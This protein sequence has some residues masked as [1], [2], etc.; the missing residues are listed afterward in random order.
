LTLT[1]RLRALRDVLQDGLVER[2]TAVRLALLAALAGEHLLLIGPP[3]T[4]KSLV[5]RR[6]GLA[7][8]DAK[9]FERLLTR[10]TVPEELFGPLSIKQLEQDRYVRQI[11]GYLPSAHVAFLDEI[12]KANSAILNAL[13]TLLNERDF[14]NGTERIRTPLIAVVGASNEL[15][16]GDELAAL[17]DRFLLKL[18]VGPVSDAGFARLLDVQ[19]GDPHVKSE[20]AL[21]HSDLEDFRRGMEKVEVP[22]DVKALLVSM[23]TWLAEQQI[24]VSDRRFGKMVRLLKASAHSHGR[25]VV[26]IWDCWLLQHCV[27]ARPE[28]REAALAWYTERVGVTADWNPERLTK[29]VGV[30][31][32]RL[33]ADQDSRSQVRDEQG[34]LLYVG[35]DGKRTTEEKSQQFYERGG[36]PVYRAPAEA[37]KSNSTNNGNGYTEDQIR[38]MQWSRQYRGY[39]YTLADW[40]GLQAYLADPKN[41]LTRIA[42]HELLLEPTPYPQAHISDRLAQTDAQVA[43]IAGWR[44]SLAAHVKDCRATIKAHLWATPDFAEPALLALTSIAKKAASLE[45]RIKRVREGFSKLPVRKDPGDD[46]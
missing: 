29:L 13:L 18:H 30:W 33:K 39:G 20:L 6:L 25:A 42:P 32:A 12:F 28:Q 26:S 14:D 40:G 2:D 23:R 7:F 22:A 3:G 4:A 38:D 10:F 37:A 15:P 31:E 45:N 43:M 9:R 1:D 44:N 21:R 19:G 36:R 34:R 35:A 16:E 17:S 41:R 27:W 5:A 24:T 11:E 8:A 46:A